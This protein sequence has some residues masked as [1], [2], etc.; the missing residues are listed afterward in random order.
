MYYLFL[1]AYYLNLLPS[2]CDPQL[3]FVYGE[4][5][6]D[7]QNASGTIGYPN[8]L[9]GPNNILFGSRY[10]PAVIKFSRCEERM[11]IKEVATLSLVF[12][13]YLRKAET[14]KSE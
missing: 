13:F 9:F 3:K 10:L 11:A 1:E 12:Q 7:N 14:D 5:S 6:I 2:S 8:I 4:I